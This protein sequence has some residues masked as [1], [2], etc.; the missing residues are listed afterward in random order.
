MDVENETMIN[1]GAMWLQKF[2][3]QEMREHI[4][5][6]TETVDRMRHVQVQWA[7]MNWFRRMTRTEWKIHESQFVE[8]K[9]N[10]HCE[11]DLC[12]FIVRER[13]IPIDKCREPLFKFILVPNYSDS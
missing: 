1:M 8:L 13:S 6:Q 9:D 10:I 4:L 12:D 11:K 5:R 2:E 7:G 3:F